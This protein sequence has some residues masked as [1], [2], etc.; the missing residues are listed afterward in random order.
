LLEIDQDAVT[1]L[2]KTML[3]AKP[4]GWHSLR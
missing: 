2:K 3:R 1:R 4:Q